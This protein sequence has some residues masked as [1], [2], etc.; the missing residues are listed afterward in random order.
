[1]KR[2]LTLVELL[3]ALAISSVLLVAVFAAVRVVIQNVVQQPQALGKI[4]EARTATAAFTNELRD[5]TYGVDGSYPIGL[6][7]TTQIVFF[8]AYNE[9][10]SAVDR[11]RYFLSS[12]TLYKGVVRPSGTS[13]TLS[14]ERVN[15]VIRNVVVS[16]TT[17]IFTY[18]D[19][20]YNGSTTTLP[21]VQPVSLTQVTF[22]QL[23]IAVLT[24]DRRNSTSTFIITTGGAIRNLKTNLSN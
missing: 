12:S 20:T 14:S 4:D 11:I 9:G 2:G 24:E 7:S 17:P 16:S 23:S 22:A 18:Y 8:S 10:G 19:G 6:A 3:V 21:L 5:A 15:A 13:Y 1:M